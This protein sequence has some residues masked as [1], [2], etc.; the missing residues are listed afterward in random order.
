MVASAW[1]SVG[2]PYDGGNLARVDDDKLVS[3]NYCQL[4]HRVISR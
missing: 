2:P 3:N 4:L 1:M